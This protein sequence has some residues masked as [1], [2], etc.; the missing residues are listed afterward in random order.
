MAI[1]S[2]PPRTV[3]V[4]Q[5][6]QG[7]YRWRKDWRLSMSDEVFETAREAIKYAAMVAAGSGAQLVQPTQGK[8]VA[9]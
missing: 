2:H 4:I 6:T 9:A 7:G 1:V 3:S 8:P 5:D